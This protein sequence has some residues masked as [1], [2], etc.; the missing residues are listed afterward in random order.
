MV[1]ASISAS[2]IGLAPLE[3]EFRSCVSTLM[4]SEA[5]I[6]PMKSLQLPSHK[7]ADAQPC[8]GRGGVGVR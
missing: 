5:L 7:G 8:R 3:T 2:L 6:T 4:K 1:C